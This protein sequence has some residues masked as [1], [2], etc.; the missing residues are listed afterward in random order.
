[1]MFTSDNNDD[2]DDCSG[3]VGSFL[4]SQHFLSPLPFLSLPNKMALMMITLY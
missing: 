2:A 3:N 1:M 4:A